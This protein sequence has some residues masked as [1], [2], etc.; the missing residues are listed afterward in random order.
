MKPY[1]LI[2]TSADVFEVVEENLE[3]VEP[4]YK[5]LKQE[6]EKSTED[7][8]EESF[9]ILEQDSNNFDKDSEDG[10]RNFRLNSS[11]KQ[12]FP[13]GNKRNAYAYLKSVWNEINLPH[14]EDAIKL[15]FY[16]TG[17]YPD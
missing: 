11:L 2:I 5:I 16:A 8:G 4:K 9:S 3:K 12:V 13:P 10:E 15:K 17:Y 1:G 6:D 7:T 14:T